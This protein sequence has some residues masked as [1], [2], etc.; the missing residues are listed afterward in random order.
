MVR[1]RFRRLT[2]NAKEGSVEK[3]LERKLDEC[4]ELGALGSTIR[5]LICDLGGTK[6]KRI[7]N[8]IKNGKLEFQSGFRT[9]GTELQLL[10]FDLKRPKPSKFAIQ[11]KTETRLNQ[12]DKVFDLDLH[13]KE[14][15]TNYVGID[16]GNRCIVGASSIKYNNEIQNLR[17]RKRAFYGP[18]TSKIQ[19]RMRLR[20]D[21]MPV[22][23][24]GRNVY[25]LE[26]DL[27]GSNESN[28]DNYLEYVNR[29]SAV[30][31]PLTRFYN[32]SQVKR[33]RMNAK[34][35]KRKIMDKIFTDVLEMVDLKPHQKQSADSETKAIIA[36]G[37]GDF[38]AT[39]GRAS[40]HTKVG[41][42]ITLKARRMQLGVYGV[43]EWY[44]SKTC[45]L[46]LN[47]D[48][49]VVPGHHMR[50]LHCP[51]HDT[52]FHRDVMAGANHALIA[53]YVCEDG[54]VPAHLRRPVDPEAQ[55]NA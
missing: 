5:T 29:W 36:I 31:R 54:T 27:F 43:D 53:K 22:G 48:V 42:Y 49:S 51:H 14:N 38:A 25:Q 35:E 33:D 41:T 26:A 47:H 17:V 24:G 15:H 44:T 12:I 3:D 39:R 10:F 46:S 4:D 55:V 9:D 8:R 21:Q 2:R 23:G 30:S 6:N 16:L 50:V 7:R 18:I 52:Y 34:K 37:M 32:T 11:N 13:Y 1:S 45:P 20:K 19:Q 28:V 40:V